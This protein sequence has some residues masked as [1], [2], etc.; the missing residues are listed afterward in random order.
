MTYSSPKK[1][2]EKMRLGLGAEICCGINLIESEGQEECSRHGEQSV[3]KD[4][5]RK[6]SYLSH[7]TG[8]ET[9]AKVS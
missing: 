1:T 5:V 8:E 7:F 6:C 2:A 3:H 4:S 9:E